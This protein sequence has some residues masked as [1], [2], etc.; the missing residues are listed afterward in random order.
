MIIVFLLVCFAQGTDSNF[1][2][3]KAIV[4]TSGRPII[5]RGHQT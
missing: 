5:L 3:S 1:E 2:L 4:P